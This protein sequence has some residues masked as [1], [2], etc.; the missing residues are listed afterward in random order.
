VSSCCQ[1][2]CY[3]PD[4]WRPYRGCC[5]CS[6][7]PLTSQFTNQ[8]FCIPDVCWM[9]SERSMIVAWMFPECSLNVPWKIHAANWNGRNTL[10]STVSLRYLSKE[11]HSWSSMHTIINQFITSPAWFQ[12]FMMM[13]V[14][15]SM[16]VQFG[17]RVTEFFRTK[18]S[19]Y[20]TNFEGG[21]RLSCVEFSDLVLF[22][23]LLLETA[24]ST[25]WIFFEVIAYVLP[26]AP[27]LPVATHTCHPPV[28]RWHLSS[29]HLF[30]RF[31]F[32]ASVRLH[33]LVF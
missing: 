9:F 13:F 19:K 2:S 1:V 8:K 12:Q 20:M 31:P 7:Q 3:R 22:Q 30:S 4:T 24:L 16:T 21:I 26:L 6:T 28:G 27:T 11:H 15:Y 17:V 18:Q 33:W 5:V 10:Y 32:L 25:E 14:E 23:R 29:S